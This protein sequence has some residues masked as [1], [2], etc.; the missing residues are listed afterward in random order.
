[1]PAWIAVG[2][3]EIPDYNGSRWICGWQLRRE[4]NVSG[5]EKF[6][7]WGGR[8]SEYNCT[9]QGPRAA[10]ALDSTPPA[11]QRTPAEHRDLRTDTV[12]PGDPGGEKRVIFQFLL[13]GREDQLS[14]S[15]WAS[16][17]AFY[18]KFY[19]WNC[20]WRNPSIR[21]PSLSPISCWSK[22]SQQFKKP[23]VVGSTQ[24]S[25]SDPRLMVFTLVHGPLHIVT[26]LVCV[27]NCIQLK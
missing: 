23:C 8:S 27:T 17:H 3:W 5:P 21:S 26:G 16:L 22:K 12:D 10:T 4:W 6:G 20:H 7:R 25:P 13:F 15:I 24:E 1:M 14:L 11:W 19:P 9:A 18:S 2:L